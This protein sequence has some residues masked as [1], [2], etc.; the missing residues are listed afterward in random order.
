MAITDDRRPTLRRLAALLT[1]AVLVVACGDGEDDTEL[2]GT[3]EGTSAITGSGP[4]ASTGAD[5]RLPPC[6][7]ADDRDDSVAS[8][9]ELDLSGIEVG[10]GSKSFAEQRG[11]GYLLVFALEEA[12]ATVVNKVN[13]GDTT[14]N[15]QALEGGG[16][17]AY[18]EYN[19]T[20]WMNHLKQIEVPDRPQALT[21]G[22]CQLDLEENGIR[23]LGRSAFSN[24]VR[25]ATPP[26]VTNDGEPF[27]VESMAAVIHQ[28]STSV[29]CVDPEFP[30]RPDG[31]A[32]L[33]EA[34]G[35]AV[36][37]D[38]I[39]VLD[40]RAVYDQTARGEC[41]FAEVY[42]TDGRIDSLDLGLVD[43]TGAMPLNNVSLTMTD[44][45]YQRA[46]REFEAI[47]DTLLRG[48]DDD[49]MRALN[50]DVV[51]HGARRAARLYLEGHHL[52]APRASSNGKAD[53]DGDGDD[54]DGAGDGDRREERPSRP[55]V[56]SQSG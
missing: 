54:D 43:D 49:A 55:D 15:R 34:M 27:T 48:L 23:W 14:Q 1:A 21:D 20:A 30:N 2:T 4:T 6:E 12:G 36:P 28:N 39:A 37:S 52:I 17:D 51:A 22:V 3:P 7:T 56:T 8:L 32:L 33:E 38:Q 50:Q 5:L 35:T 46:P 19:G 18:W 29:L 16:I 53:G 26:G 13:L 42:N 25:F 45:L 11:L 41:D 47:A 44:D 9:S 10:V 40:T 31:L 24:T